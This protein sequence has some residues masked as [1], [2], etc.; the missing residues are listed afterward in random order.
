MTIFFIYKK[1]NFLLFILIQI[2]FLSCNIS[3]NGKKR[4][5]FGNYCIDVYKTWWT[6]YSKAYKTLG[7]MTPSE[8]KAVNGI[9]SFTILEEENISLQDLIV[10]CE[11]GAGIVQSK[12]NNLTIVKKEIITEEVESNTIGFLIL[13]TYSNSYGSHYRYRYH[14]LSRGK[15]MAFDL[16]VVVNYKPSEETRKTVIS[17]IKSFSDKCD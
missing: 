16:N 10:F 7:T 6:N 3:S 11:K 4:E 14:T 13:Y 1:R 9:I 17:I 2:L 12:N 8:K 5:K 15:K